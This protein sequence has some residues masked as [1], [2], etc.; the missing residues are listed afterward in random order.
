MRILLAI[1]DSKFSQA[2]MRAVIQQAPPQDSEIQV[3][4]V[5]EPPSPLVARESAGYNAAFDAEWW[6]LEKEQAQILVEKAVDLLRSKSLKATASVLEGHIKSK[7][8]DVAKDWHADLIVLGSHGRKGLM[9]FLIGS[10]SEG[11]ALH[12]G[13]SVEVVRIPPEATSVPDD[14]HSESR[15]R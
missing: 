10:V 7:I 9:H 15:S 8:L 3:L 13:C 1:D 11:V 5:L 2:A 4:H 6:Q 14:S 12:A